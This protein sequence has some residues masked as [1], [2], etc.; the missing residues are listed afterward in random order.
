MATILGIPARLNVAGL[1]EG[2]RDVNRFGY[3]GV[4][5]DREENDHFGTKWSKERVWDRVTVS[6][7]RFPRIA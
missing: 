5:T 1:K 6:A 7:L 3:G 2:L 4:L